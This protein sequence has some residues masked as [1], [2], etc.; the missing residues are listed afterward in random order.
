MDGQLWWAYAFLATLRSV[1]YH[2]VDTNVTVLRKQTL[3]LSLSR[4]PD[5]GPN[6]TL[7]DLVRSMYLG[8]KRRY[9]NTL[10]FLSFPLT[11]PT[12]VDDSWKTVLHR[13]CYYH[14]LLECDKENMWS[15]C[16]KRRPCSPA[17][18]EKWHPCSRA[19]LDT[20]VTNA[21]TAR[22]NGPW[23]RASFGTPVFT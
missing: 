18:V 16:T 9:I 21:A 15:S 4:C 14:T 13:E 10:H 2:N 8:A 23:K 20:L 11:Q 12:A 7:W 6:T 3:S 17:G 19:V 22:V 1:L 5:A